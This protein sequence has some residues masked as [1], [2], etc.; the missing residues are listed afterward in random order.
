MLIEKELKKIFRQLLQDDI[1]HIDV[2]GFD[3]TVRVFDQASKLSLSTPVYF[4]GNFIP[5][6]VRTSLSQKVP[7]ARDHVKAY[8]SVD[9][10]NYQINLNYLG[11]LNGLQNE[12]FKGLLEDFSWLASEWRL[13]LDE[14]D[15]NDL[16][17]VR[18]K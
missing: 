1:A 4:G 10:N 13:F 14:H 15:K 18:V 3:V 8:L 5:K 7:F 2:D 11:R 9:E 17:H 16:I 6:S 12:T